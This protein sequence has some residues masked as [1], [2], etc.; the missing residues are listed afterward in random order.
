MSF[1]HD[2]LLL[3]IRRN[4]PHN[5][6]KSVANALN[7]S[8]HTVENWFRLG[9]S[10]GFDTIGLMVGVWGPRFLADV[11]DPAPK[12]AT[13]SAIREELRQLEVRKTEL[14]NKF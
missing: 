14:E 2:K 3:F 9:T 13:E 11:L 10:P 1:S 7:I 12:W 5:T 6:T 8:P 4:Y